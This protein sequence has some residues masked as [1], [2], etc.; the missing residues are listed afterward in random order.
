MAMKAFIYSREIEQ[1]GYPPSCPFNTTRA[2][3]ARDMLESMGLLTGDDRRQVP[4]RAATA[5][6]LLTFHTP[7]YLD[8]LRRAPLEGEY[9]LGM[10]QMG[11]GTGDCPVFKGMYEYAAL[12]A[13]A[14]IVGAEL[15]ASG[16]A[17]VAFNPSGGYHHAFPELAAGFC[18]VNDVVLACLKLTAAG[19]RVVYLDIDVHHGD[20]V[21]AAFYDR[22]DVMTISLHESG[23]TLFPG[24]GFPDEIGEGEGEGYSVNVPLPPGTYDEVWLEAF[25]AVAVP[26]IGAFDPDA[27]VI[28]AGMD[29]LS[30]DPLAH[31]SLTNNAHAT[32]LDEVRRFG[33]GILVVGGGG[34]N[35]DNAARG[36][37]LAWS[38]LC[39]EDERHAMDVGL[40]GV[41]LAS[42]EWRGGLRDRT[43]VPDARQVAQV[44]PA[45]RETVE[46]VKAN[47]FPI[48]G[49]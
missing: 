5:E 29:A 14:S 43:L 22:D 48:H 47:I 7:R 42:S 19:K 16:Q 25:D 18:Y 26:L 4:L 10:M 45:V 37:A 3:R 39:G 8:A 46:T 20:G 41:L 34:Y 12:A 49:L 23:Q 36:W 35:P 27:I 38:V 2:G 6:E 40:G 11:L 31:L 1:Y 44:A 32:A 13:G 30:G 17:D 15:V 24:T 9:E 21:Q 33:K 28:E